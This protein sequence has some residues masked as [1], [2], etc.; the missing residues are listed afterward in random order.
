MHLISKLFP[1]LGMLAFALTVSGC[2]IMH[3]TQLGEIDSR[4]VKKGR[5]F[6][7][8][9]SE[10]GFNLDEAA[11]IGKAM[12]QH[13]K[14]RDDIAA[15]QAIIGLFQMGPRTGNQVLTDAYADQVFDLLRKE[16]P[17]GRISGLMSV[18]ETAKYPVISGEIVKVS[19]FCLEDQA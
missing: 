12:T 5:R 3:H 16:C 9:V 17:K 6:Q 4:V 2:A 18:R 19:G 15:V 14:T 10:T 13:Q 8:L 11:A 7:I 1:R